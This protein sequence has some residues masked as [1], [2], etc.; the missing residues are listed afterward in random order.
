M[1]DSTQADQ[2]QA[3]STQITS[4]DTSRQDT[5]STTRAVEAK[6]VKDLPEWAQ[7]Q[8]ADLRKESAGY[9]KK[10]QDFE[11]RDKSELT[12]AQEA[13]QAAQDEAKTVTGRLRMVLA[14]QAVRD[15]AESAG[16]IS[17]RAVF[18]Y[19]R[20]DLD[21]DDEGN[22]TNLDAV[23]K[24]AKRDEPKLFGKGTADGG[25]GGGTQNGAVDMN[26]LIRERAGYRG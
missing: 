5:T 3:D 22:V 21:F 18:R 19:V 4:T 2:S 6:E 14:E 13:A 17:A 7:K 15:A 23:L 16:A 11:D 8:I 26:R 20:D 25:K 1:S 12:K 24:A 10:A 9:R